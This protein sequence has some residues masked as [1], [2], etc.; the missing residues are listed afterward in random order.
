M[1]NK[2]LVLRP[3]KWYIVDLTDPRRPSVS[4]T[5]WVF[6][7]LCQ[8]A[9]DYHFPGNPLIEPTLGSEIM[10]SGLIP[11]P[12]KYGPAR[13]WVSRYPYLKGM[14]TKEKITLISPL[15]R[16]IR[17]KKYL[18]ANGIKGHID[19]GDLLPKNFK[20]KDGKTIKNP[21]RYR[22]RHQLLRA[23]TKGYDHL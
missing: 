4:S 20:D 6:K 18:E 21:E 10:E 11:K 17:R 7:E 13:F 3:T 12:S 1:A 8:R 2:P 23:M 15:H 22:V 19:W 9:I 16:R 5:Y 14:T